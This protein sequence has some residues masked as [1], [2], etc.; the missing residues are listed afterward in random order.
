MYRRNS[1]V[2]NSR[3]LPKGPGV[4]SGAISSSGLNGI[5][6]QAGLSP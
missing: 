4:R 6:Y 5:G 2:R 1:R 3:H